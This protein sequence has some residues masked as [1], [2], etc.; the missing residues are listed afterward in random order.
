MSLQRTQQ[1]VEKAY[2]DLILLD[3][4]VVLAERVTTLVGSLVEFNDKSNEGKYYLALKTLDT[5][6]SNLESVPSCRLSRNLKAF[7]EPQTNQIIVGSDFISP[8]RIVV[9]RPFWSGAAR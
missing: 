8:C 7:I 5:L 1:H 6:K 2:E 9:V 3:N 4:M